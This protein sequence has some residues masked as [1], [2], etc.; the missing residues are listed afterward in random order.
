MKFTRQ[1]LFSIFTVLFFFVTISPIIERLEVIGK[2]NLSFLRMGIGI[3][4]LIITI[5]FFFQRGLSF[6]FRAIVIIAILYLFIFY[7]LLISAIYKEKIT[8]ITFYIIY[9]HLVFFG[10]VAV[11]PENLERFEKLINILCF[12]AITVGLFMTIVGPEKIQAMGIGAIEGKWGQFT[13]TDAQTTTSVEVS[14]FFRSFS[15]FMDHQVFSVFLQLCAFLYRF[16]YVIKKEK[17]Y[18]LYIIALLVSNT[19]T[20]ST[21]G[22]LAIFIILL[23]FVK[24]RYTLLSI[25][26]FVIAGVYFYIAYPYIALLIFHLGSLQMRLEYIQNALHMVQVLPSLNEMEKIDFSSDC[27]LLWM[28]YKYGIIY[29]VLQ[30]ALLFSFIG[31]L[32]LK[33]KDTRLPVLLLSFVYFINI[34]TNAVCYSTPNNILLPIL[35]GMVAYYSIYSQQSLNR[36]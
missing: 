10:Y 22:F 17:K 11:F 24:F 23:S 18:I 14:L 3:L 33:R 6:N 7:I 8:E 5:P 21:T 1:H 27:Y 9:I 4:L 2:P 28:T 30:F 20:F 19:M 32:T 16:L 34:L 31:F 13:T 29:T 12:I 26:C 35:F 25:L 36:S 15:I